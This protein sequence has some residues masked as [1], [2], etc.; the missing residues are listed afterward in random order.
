MTQHAPMRDFA[1]EVFFSKHEFTAR[2]HMTASD[3][4]SRT[5]Q[6]V[7]SLATDE[8]RGAFESLWLGYTETWGSPALRAEIAGLYQSMNPDN[9]LCLAGAGEGLYAAAKV[10]LTS[11]DHVI[12]PI[13]NYQSAETVPLS[14]CS[15]TGVSQRKVVHHG[16]TERWFLDPAEIM[17]AVQPTTKLISLNFPNN[18]TGMIMA[19]DDLKALV[20]FCRQRGI[21][22]LCDEVY[23]GVELDLKDQVSQ[24]ADLYERGISLNVMSKAY[25]LP[26]IRIGWLAS[27][28]RDLLQKIERYKHFLSICNSGPS[29]ALALIALKARD[30]ILS[31]NKRLLEEN[32]A[33]LEALWADYP[34][35]V[36][37][38]R[39]QG[40]CVAY[41]KFK[42]PEGGEAFCAR[43]LEEDG[44]LLLPSSIYRSEIGAAPADH[45]RIGFGRDQVFKEGVT[46]LRQHFERRYS[47]FRL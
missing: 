5:V 42:G 30:R 24:I 28:D 13:P 23:R 17:A 43:L 1:L 25:G 10:L 9:I 12:V 7:L 19:E 39:P 27:Q 31:D 26:G 8:D 34:D 29:E 3:I 11:E 47:A 14:L 45:F 2:H 18:P 20:D 36:D 41:P 46:A 22:I 35:L 40:G 16:G 21:Y 37:W 6:D 38:V 33:L 15:V 44:V 4:E 32:L